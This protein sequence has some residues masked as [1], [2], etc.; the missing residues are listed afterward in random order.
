MKKSVSL[1]S[2]IALIASMVLTGCNESSVDMEKIQHIAENFNKISENLSNIDTTK[3]VESA[4]KTA[5]ISDEFSEWVEE[6]SEEIAME[7]LPTQEELEEFIDE[8][9]NI[10]DAESIFADDVDIFDII[11]EEVAY[12][13][14]VEPITTQMD[15]YT[16]QEEEILANA[17]N[18][19]EEGLKKIRE[20]LSLINDVYNKQ[21]MTEES[22]DKVIDG[23]SL[24]VEG[25]NEISD[26]A[27]QLIT[28]SAKTANEIIVQAQML[29]IE[30][31]ELDALKE[32]LAQAQN[33]KIYAFSDDT[34]K[35][36]EEVKAIASEYGK[37]ALDEAEKVKVDVKVNVDTQQ[38]QKNV[39]EQL[40]AIPDYANEAKEILGAANDAAKYAQDLYKQIDANSKV[41]VEQAKELIK[42][43]DVA[44][45]ALKSYEQV[46]EYLD[47]IPTKEL[48][49]I[50]KKLDEII[51]YSKSKDYKSLLKGLFEK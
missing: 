42:G 7:E 8:E 11:D 14:F 15:V 25:A 36:I 27:T 1:I 29:G 50:E 9:T 3:L 23:A 10:D 33:I 5:E 12:E 6:T 47:A 49:D 16:Q 39:E 30:S 45:D 38:I 13:M 2:V 24:I 28:E 34:V 21:D 20:G 41:V 37:K 17:N 40:E 18:K 46:G 35:Q 43:Y 48:K 4:E 19:K 22:V 32:C 44:E 31:E 26:G 51:K